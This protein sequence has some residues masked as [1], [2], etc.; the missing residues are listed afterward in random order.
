M[1]TG[2]S[3]A[4]YSTNACQAHSFS[5]MS[6][7]AM[8]MCLQQ[9][10]TS[11]EDTVIFRYTQASWSTTDNACLAVFMNSMVYRVAIQR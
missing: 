2:V 10:Q 4:V 3:S 7:S 1:R 8:L 6:R 5:N 9:E 11:C